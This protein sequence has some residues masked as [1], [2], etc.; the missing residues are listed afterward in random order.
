MGVLASIALPIY[1]SY[2]DTAEEGVLRGNVNTIEIFQEDFFLR[3]G[4]YSEPHANLAAITTA[5]GWDPRA[6]TG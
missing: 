3:N 2:T 5:T 4:I 1:S 6:V